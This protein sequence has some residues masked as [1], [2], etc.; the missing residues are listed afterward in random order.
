MIGSECCQAIANLCRQFMGYKKADLQSSVENFVK[1]YG[2]PTAGKENLYYWYYGTLCTFQQGGD[3][4]NKWNA[5]MQEALLST[6]ARD[7]NDAGSWT[8][9]GMYGANWGRV[10]QTSLAALCLEVYYRYSKLTDDK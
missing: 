8:P 5:A 4:W 6:Q 2:V 7:G 3:V 10:G 1:Q 9:T